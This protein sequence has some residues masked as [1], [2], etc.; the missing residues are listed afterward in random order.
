MKVAANSKTAKNRAENTHEPFINIT[1]RSSSS[2]GRSLVVRTIAIVSALIICAIFTVVLTGENPINVFVSM[3]EANFG[4]LNL[5]MVSMQE[6]AILL[7]V[8]LAV[9]PAFRM[10]FWNCGAEGQ[11]LFG[12]LAAAVVMLLFGGKIND[13]LL[14]AATFVSSILAGIIWGVIPSVFKAHW[15]TNETL[16]TLMMNYVAIQLV[17][18]FIK[19]AAKD[20]S[21]VVDPDMLRFSTESGELFTSVEKFLIIAG[22]AVIVTI[23][24]FVYLNYTKHGYEISVVGESENTA[25]YIGIN[26]KKV[27]VRTMVISG[28]I[29]GIVGFLLV[30]VSSRSIN[31]DI[32]SGRGFTAIMVSWLAKFNPVIMI[33]TSFLLV[34]LKIGAG[35]VA[36]NF[37]LSLSFSDILTGIILFFIIGCEFFLNYKVHFNFSRLSFR[38]K[39]VK[40]AEAEK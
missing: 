4:N 26:V 15:N 27:I 13:I 32:V 33:I 22:F 28:G 3:F 21:S 39:T 40:K 6:L 9:T 35:N 37:R 25:K 11:A 17:K 7:L 16:F 23:F 30:T 36:M 12:G 5:L 34:F 31:P 24:S 2:I 8:S 1:R 38:K 14:L 29:C 19:I 18:F 20:G 10:K